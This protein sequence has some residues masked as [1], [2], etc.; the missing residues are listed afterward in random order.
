[1]F[2]GRNT[3]NEDLTGAHF[4]HQ[5][6][7]QSDPVIGGECEWQEPGRHF[8]VGLSRKRAEARDP[9]PLGQVLK[10][11]GFAALRVL[12]QAQRIHADLPRSANRGGG[13]KERY[14]FFFSKRTLS[15]LIAQSK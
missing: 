2:E 4:L 1:M 3:W 6:F 13:T 9:L 12:H 7:N 15:V 8:A 14:C 10:P 11:C 5:R